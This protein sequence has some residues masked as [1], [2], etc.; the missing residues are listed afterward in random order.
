MASNQ[1]GNVFTVPVNEKQIGYGHVI[2]RFEP[3]YYMVAYD[4]VSSINQSSHVREITNSPILFLGNF[5]DNLISMGHW[6]VIGNEPPELS[7]IPFPT[8]KVQIG[9]QYFIE[10]WDG[11]KR[12]LATPE[13]ILL[14]DFRDS[15][16]PICLEKAL[17]AY[18]DNGPWD[19]FFNRMTRDY[20]EARSKVQWA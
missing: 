19:T 10:T 14:M 17:Q 13:E 3:V 7:R 12:R 8:Y 5:F 18:F 4:R 20:V 15:S 11:A 9:N 2:A 6:K 1:V 16:G